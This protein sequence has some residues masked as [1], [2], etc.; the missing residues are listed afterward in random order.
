MPIFSSALTR[1]T[2]GFLLAG[3]LALLAIVFT[4]IWLTE[5]T[6][7]HAEELARARSIRTQ[8]STMLS[9]L[10][11]AETAQRGFLLTEADRYLE[12]Y[13]AV[14][15][16]LV[17]NLHALRELVGDNARAVAQVEQLKPIVQAK[18]AELDRTIE[19]V[20]A[21]RRDEAL[22]IVNSDAGKKLMDQARALLKAVTDIA[23]AR[24]SDRLDKLDDSVELL[25]WTTIVGSIL[26]V[27]FAAGASYTV[28]AYTRGLL[29]A[30]QEVESLNAGLEDRI[31]ERT[32]ALSRA[33]DEI[34]RF[35]YIV[36]HDL[37]SPLVNVMGFTSELEAGIA[38]VHKYFE[39][40]TPDADLG[41][42]A[43]TAVNED[44]PEAV[45][46]IRASTAKMDGLINAI[47][48][49]SREGRRQ[50]HPEPVDLDQLLAQAAA[51]IK[52]QL[53][54]AGGEIVLPQR[55]FRIVSDRLA[56]E[57]VFGNL[58]DN[59][60]KYLDRGRPLRIKVS[61]EHYARGVRVLV[62]DNGRGIAEADH[63]RIFE[64]FR[65]AGA[66]DRPGEGIGLAH[67]RALV[68]RLGGD[69]TVSSEAGRGS[70]F[71]IVLPL[72]IRNM[73]DR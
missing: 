2:F 62:A 7:D 58:L 50:L 17:D 29:R 56:L 57:Q 11:D 51:S 9:D 14:R 54:E 32:S 13:E 16:R 22:R 65:R 69:I 24:V 19:L 34:Q 59:A 12:P 23:D 42:Q 36:S 68:R 37:R 46:F 70:T 39:A 44:F 8:T 35:A 67:V 27:L 72:Q 61:I 6:R 49:L 63:E 21:G 28:M 40:E 55:R 71:E 31:R 48:R 33:N 41:Q 45:R 15:P 10:I 26:I 4:S 3:T 38:T 73:E 53:D 60:V 25:S 66:Q 1:R 5:R 20:K 43:R 47:L 64:L 52:H 30:R 18:V